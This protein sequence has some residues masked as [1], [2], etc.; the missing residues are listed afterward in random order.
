MRREAPCKQRQQV[1][2][3]HRGRR[4]AL[5]DIGRHAKQPELGKPGSDGS[6]NHQ[7][8]LIA[9]CMQLRDVGHQPADGL[10]LQ[11]SVRGDEC[12]AHLD[13]QATNAPQVA[14][15]LAR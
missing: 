14:T 13:D 3:T 4:L 12:T 10:L 9:L 15:F 2:L 11:A 7:N 6:R 5:D 8:G 1:W